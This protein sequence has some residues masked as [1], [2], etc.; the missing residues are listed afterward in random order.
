MVPGSFTVMWLPYWE[1]A[2]RPPACSGL[3]PLATFLPHSRVDD[4]QDVYRLLPNSR[5][6]RHSRPQP[7]LFPELRV[8]LPRCGYGQRKTDTGEV[9][10][11]EG[12]L[13]HEPPKKT[14]FDGIGYRPAGRSWRQDQA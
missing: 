1:T 14:K 11:D 7:M 12:K 3:W 8:E 13:S 2:A 4:H 6:G 5:C 10:L 9:R